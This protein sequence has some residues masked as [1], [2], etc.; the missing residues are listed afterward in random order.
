MAPNGISTGC[1]HGELA[2]GADYEFLGSWVLIW[3]MRVLFT[4][5]RSIVGYCSWAR[6]ARRT[7]VDLYLDIALPFTMHTVIVPAN[8]T[9]IIEFRMLN[10]F[11]SYQK[12]DQ[13]LIY[14]LLTNLCRNFVE[15]LIYCPYYNNH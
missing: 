13:E 3:W 4:A 12:I 14:V 11:A 8:S 7:P 1:L 2:G 15:I 5:R 9:Q 6:N 10:C